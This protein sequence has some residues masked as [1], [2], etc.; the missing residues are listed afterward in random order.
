[1]NKLI[2]GLLLTLI[3]TVSFAGAYRCTGYFNNVAI[4]PSITVKASKAAV[5]ET[6]AKSRMKKDGIEVDYVVCK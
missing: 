6:K 5:A 4:D 3:S 1:M 2:A